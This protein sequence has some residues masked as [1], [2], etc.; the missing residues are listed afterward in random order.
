M[1]V[2]KLHECIEWSKQKLEVPCQNRVHAVKQFVGMHYS[3][4]GSE[5]RVPTNF[6]ELAVTIYLRLLATRAPR[7]IVKSK[8]LEL[9]PFAADLEE[10]LNQIPGEIGLDRTL[11]RAVM[12]A[13]FSMA[14]VK[15]GIGETN[16]NAKI[17]D[18][19][20][21]SLVQLDD[22]FVDMSARSW[23][24]VQYEGNEYWMDRQQIADFYGVS[25]DAD[26]DSSIST[27]GVEQAKSVG[28]NETAKTWSDRV[29]LRD[30][31]LVREGRLVTYA[32]NSL[33]ILRDVPWDGP[34]GTPYLKLWFEEVPGNLLPLSPVN[35]WRDLHELANSLFRKLAKQADSKK[36][37]LAFQGGND[38]EIQRFRDAADGDGIRY[39]GGK[40]EELAAGGV[41]TGNLA[42]YIQV[43]DLYNIFAGNLDSLGGLSPQA[44]TATQEKLISE[45]SSARVQDMID[46]TVDF[47]KAIFRRLAWYVWT[48]PI[49]ERKVTKV[50]SSDLGLAVDV[51]WTPETRDGDF[52]D[53]NIDIDV[54]SMQD[55]SPA[56]RIQKLLSVFERLVLP[57][58]E[59][60][61]AQGA[62]IDMRRL[63]EYVGKN[64]NLPELSMFVQFADQTPS[65]GNTYGNPQPEYTSTKSPYSRRVYER[66]NRPGATRHGRDAALMQTLLGG[67]AQPADMA[68]LSMGRS[69][70]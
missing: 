8:S 40:P 17:G 50:A 60:L 16:E 52:L 38:E 35:T 59:Q 63:L 26:E 32:V 43:K 33:K 22:Y 44:D 69:M 68:A 56:T 48:D 4:N 27:G 24:E 18:E 39:N 9:V 65:T 47:A 7:C 11:R 2:N 15:V 12:E 45:A 13:L 36:S 62:Y 41:D 28:V 34:E 53:Y 49:R 23:E 21:V 51:N 10:V 55:D 58:Q 6:L 3:D 37:V 31:Y 70:T 57:M 20:F 67:G 42:F 25:L 30:V 46:R 14:V 66:V 29:L 19:P 64:S 1:D 5:R 54:F 61:M